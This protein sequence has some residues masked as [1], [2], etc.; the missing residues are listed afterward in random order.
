MKHLKTKLGL[1]VLALAC[2][3]AGAIS[4]Q[5]SYD[6][7]AEG[8]ESVA[9]VS[10]A[11]GLVM[12]NGAMV[13]VATDWSGI[14]WETTV[15]AGTYAEGTKFGVIVAP[16]ASIDEGE[17]LTHEN[18]YIVD[19]EAEGFTASAKK[20]KVFYSAINYNNLVNETVSLK[21]A[22]A[23][24]LT[25]RAY[26]QIGEDCYYAD[27]T[28]INTSRSARQVAIAAELDGA[29]VNEQAEAYKYYAE[30]Y[31]VYTAEKRYS[32]TVQSI[33]AA[34]T[35]YIDKENPTATVTVALDL[36]SDTFQEA[37]IGAERIEASYADGTLTITE[38][39]YIPTGEGYYITVFTTGGTIYTKP[40]IGATK[41]FDSPDDFEAFKYIR[42]N[43]GADSKITY[44]IL[45]KNG[46]GETVEADKLVHDGYYVLASDL[47]FNA[48]DENIYDYSDYSWKVDGKTVKPGS[49]IGINKFADLPLGLTGTFNGLGHIVKNYRTL[50]NY[51]GLFELING[52][53]VKNLGLYAMK[54]QDSAGE[55]FG[56]Y[57]TGLAW[58]AI[59]AKIENVYVQTTT[60]FFT[61]FKQTAM[62]GYI[63]QSEAQAFNL[64]NVYMKAS[65]KN[66]A[67][68][69]GNVLTASGTGGMFFAVNKYSNMDFQWE[70]VYV[71]SHAGLCTTVTITEETVDE[72]TQQVVSKMEHYAYGEKQKDGDSYKV[73]S[74]SGTE[75]PES[76]D[77]TNVYEIKGAYVYY[78]VDYSTITGDITTAIRKAFYN[79]PS[80][81]WTWKTNKELAFG[82][83][84]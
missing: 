80:N 12:T 59:D 51:S 25:A 10:D 68:G 3:G 41:V 83:T 54:G 78:T 67:D 39:N 76:V 40:V 4:L 8:T 77:P 65:Y 64:R 58:F 14:R 72:V 55:T 71:L 56:K 24:E 62:F 29:L 69:T 66:D 63:Y 81:C 45:E 32:T 52:G 33:G 57:S 28:G 79:D 15:K 11:S 73:Y 19:I 43:F 53:T 2:L 75:V 84:A 22:Y 74:W 44:E 26:V 36:G 20:D 34:G 9:T 27:M 49:W 38:A 31:E 60:N 37:L 7:K 50:R 42:T 21:D 13:R 82:A 5:S 48:V 61:E 47:D 30:G 18:E 6:A 23:L 17:E 35:P 46:A 70:N 1:S 16:T